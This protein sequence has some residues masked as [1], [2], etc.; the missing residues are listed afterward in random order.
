MQRYRRLLL[1]GIAAAL[2]LAVAPAS[3]DVWAISGYGGW[4]GSFNS[5]V[6]FTGPGTDWTVRDVPWDGVSFAKD[7][8][9]PYYG[10]R[11]TYWPSAWRNVGI[12]IDYTHAKI[13]AQ[14][15]ATVSY[16]GTINGGSL[17]PSGSDTVSNLFD[18]LEFTDGL[19]LITLNGIYGLQRVG[20]FHPYVGAGVGISIPHVEVTGHGPAVPFPRTFAYEFGGPAV[21]ALVGVDVDVTSHLSLFG[22]YKLS[23]TTV[24]SGMT[25]GDR[26]HT[27]VTTN[28]LLVG[29]T[30]K[31][32]H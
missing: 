23:W 11:V 3:A 7:G 30:L 19:S 16:S 17:P 13:R 28:H 26:I 12:A 15:N 25:G 5:D 21:Q 22:E 29:A 31:F 20:V 27:N 9:A 1:Q 8:G 4:N 6:H 32:G 14:R 24:N 2:F 18:V 10:Y